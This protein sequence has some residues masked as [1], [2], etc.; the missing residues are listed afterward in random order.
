VP[1]CHPVRWRRAAGL[2]A[3]TALV[4][5]ACAAVGG[6]DAADSPIVV[7]GIPDQDLQ[8]LEERFGRVAAFLSEA[9][10]VEVVYRPAT[11]YAAL[12]SAFHNG[13]VQLGWFGGLTGLQAR[14]GVPGAHAVAQRPVDREFRSVFVAG[15][16]SGVTTLADLRGRSLTF[17]SESSTSGHLMPRAELVAAGI[18]PER[19]LAGPP[20]YSGSHDKTWKLVEAGTFDAGALNATVWEEAVGTGAVDTDRVRVVATTGPYTDYH[21]VTHPVLDERF[22]AGTTARIVA[23]LLALDGDEPGEAAVLDAF[24]TDRFVPARDADYDD[25]ARVARD[26]GLLE[27]AR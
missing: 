1:R 22:G 17:G 5:P 25:V 3:A 6:A 12:V 7:G 16:G 15:V 4:L 13:D 8:R 23:A 21:W 20:G 18:D 14:N 10:G 11:S 2:L 9:L 27:D 26:L 19:D 24:G